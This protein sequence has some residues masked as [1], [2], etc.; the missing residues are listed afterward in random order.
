MAPGRSISKWSHT[1]GEQIEAERE[2]DDTLAITQ[3][4]DSDSEPIC[5]SSKSRHFIPTHLQEGDMEMDGP[6]SKALLC[7]LSDVIKE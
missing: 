7:S 3:S 5:M 1:H 2:D 4:E 6:L